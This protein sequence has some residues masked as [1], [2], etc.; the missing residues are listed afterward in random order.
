MPYGHISDFDFGLRYVLSNG[1]TVTYSAEDNIL[2]YLK[3][4]HDNG[5]HKETNGFSRAVVKRQAYY[6]VFK[7]SDMRSPFDIVKVQPADG[8]HELSLSYRMIEDYSRYKIN[9][10]YGISLDKFLLLPQHLVRHMFEIAKIRQAKEG[11]GINPLADELANQIKQQEK[12]LA[13]QQRTLE[14]PFPQL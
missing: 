6:E 3:H 13:Q 11:D 1:K 12:A 9:Q 7:I 8:F 2:R 10:Y 4:I 5:W 14:S